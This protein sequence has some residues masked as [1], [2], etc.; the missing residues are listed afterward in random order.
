MFVL[1]VTGNN[2]IVDNY[3]EFTVINYTF[4][5]I[6]F[7]VSLERSFCHFRRRINATAY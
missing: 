7:P 6:S 3:D 5:S 1:A 4:R 2:G